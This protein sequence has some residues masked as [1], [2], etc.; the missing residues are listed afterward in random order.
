[1]EFINGRIR[2][3]I[4]REI[5]ENVFEDIH[6]ILTGIIIIIANAYITIHAGTITII[7]ITT[8]TYK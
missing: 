7:L 6:R 2:L 8:N 5:W 3:F 1:M 4:I